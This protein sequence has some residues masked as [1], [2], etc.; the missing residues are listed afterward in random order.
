MRPSRHAALVT[1]ALVPIGTIAGHVAGYG[2]AGR[3]AGLDGDHGHLRPLAWITAVAAL[4]ALGWV[5]GGSGRRPV[6]LPV[7]RLAT[8]QAALFL[9]LE[10]GEHLAAGRGIGHLL[11]EP[12]LRWGL[13]AQIATAAV[14]AVTARFARASG[15]RVRALLSARTRRPARPVVALLRWGATDAVPNLTPAASASERGPPRSLA[16]V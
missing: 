2:L 11:S 9:A 12:A 3:H 6:R 1:A 16:S 13:L 5:A 10:S 4:A 14:L 15:A 7:V 8:C